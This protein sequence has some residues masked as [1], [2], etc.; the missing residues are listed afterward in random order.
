MGRSEFE[1][2]KKQLL[3]VEKIM[4]TMQRLKF[5]DLN[6][7]RSKKKSQKKKRFLIRIEERCEYRMRVKFNYNSAVESRLIN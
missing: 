2:K 1:K 7:I 5:W 6:Q 4:I 3:T